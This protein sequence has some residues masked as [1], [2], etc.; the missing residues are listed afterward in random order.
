MEQTE[1]SILRALSLP[2]GLADAAD[3][4]S[5]EGG[6]VTQTEGQSAE[7]KERGGKMKRGR[8]A[9]VNPR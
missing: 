5:L 4:T 9:K 2:Q 8:T 3:Y 6:R 7:E 1:C